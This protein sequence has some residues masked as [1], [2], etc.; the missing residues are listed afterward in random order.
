MLPD[1]LRPFK[2]YCASPSIN[3][4]LVLFLWQTIEIDPLGHV[5]VV[6][7]LQNFVQK[8]DS[9][10]LP[11]F[12]IHQ[13]GQYYTLL[14]QWRVFEWSRNIKAN[15]VMSDWCGRVQYQQMSEFKW[16]RMFGLWETGLTY[17]IISVWIGNAAMTVMHVRNQWIEE[18]YI[19]MS[20]YCI[21]QCNPSMGWSFFSLGHHGLYTSTAV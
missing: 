14:S 19:E 6:E 16:G 5:K 9:V 13:Q 11:E 12:H 10:I 7:A 2:I 15:A 18:S 8:Y 3:S 17:P 1:T 4:K 21:T 20:R